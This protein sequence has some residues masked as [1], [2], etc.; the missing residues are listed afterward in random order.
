MTAGRAM[1]FVH[2]PVARPADW[3][4]ARRLQHSRLASRA[5]RARGDHAPL[6]RLGLRPGASPAKKTFCG[7]AAEASH[8]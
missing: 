2:P 4:R 3:R 7:R 1:T 8:G 6:E 5:D